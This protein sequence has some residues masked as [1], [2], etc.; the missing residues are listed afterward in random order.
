LFCFLSPA[1]IT[2]LWFFSSPTIGL[3]GFCQYLGVQSLNSPPPPT[4][5]RKQ[6]QT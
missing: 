6:Q 5:P 3:G 4:G 2:L 1:N